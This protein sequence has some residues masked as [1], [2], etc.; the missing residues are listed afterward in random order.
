MD[1]PSANEVFY[2]KVQVLNRDTS[3]TVIRLYQEIMVKERE[4]KRKKSEMR[5]RFVEENVGGM[6]KDIPD[7]TE[8]AK[9]ELGDVNW[10]D[11]VLAESLARAAHY[12]DPV[13]NP[14]PEG[15]GLK[16]LDCL[17]ASGLRSMRYH[18]EIQVRECGGRAFGTGGG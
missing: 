18:K 8:A 13:N 15:D 9:T 3:I 16:I 1:F 2:N 4:V 7:F 11:F 14:K 6:Q 17:A 5:K 10:T 12:G